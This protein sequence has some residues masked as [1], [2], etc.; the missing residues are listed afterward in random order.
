NT[1][2]KRSECETTTDRWS[3][4]VVRVIG[5]AGAMRNRNGESA[6][7]PGICNSGKTVETLGEVMIEIKRPFV[8]GASARGAE[9]SGYAGRWDTE[10]VLP[11]LIPGESDVG[12][13]A[14]GILRTRPPDVHQFFMIEIV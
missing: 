1:Q 3:K 13:A 4:V 10:G 14:V 8:E 2:R 11:L 9:I 7:Y 5:D 6:A 12:F